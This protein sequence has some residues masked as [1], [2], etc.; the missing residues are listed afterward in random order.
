MN[1]DIFIKSFTKDNF[2]Q[3]GCPACCSGFLKMDEK[4]YISCITE[5]SRVF[6]ELS[7]EVNGGIEH[8][9]FIAKCEN[10]RCNEIVTMSGEIEIEEKYKMED[11]I[12]IAAGLVDDVPISYYINYHD[13]KYTYPTLNIINIDE[14]IP[15]QIAETLKESFSLFWN[16]QSSAGNK[17]RNVVEL[18]M[19][20]QKIIK[21]KKNKKGDI[22][23]LFLHDRLLVFEKNKNKLG[24]SLMS[25]KW[26]GNTGSHSSTLSKDDILD[27]Y[28]ILEYVF[29]E[30]YISK[31]K[32]NKIKKISKKMTKKFKK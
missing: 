8:F 14:A 15:S 16:H 32:E 26:L 23:N 4:L 22:V 27:A 29:G 12:D 2:P 19:D 1:R 11:P 24:K 25:V 6:N 18:L 10:S 3:F 9:S 17:I 7:G 30:L 20:D 21:T 28:E 5:A 31:K 13:I